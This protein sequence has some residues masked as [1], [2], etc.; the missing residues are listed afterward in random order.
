MGYLRLEGSSDGATE[1]VKDEPG[2]TI[3]ITGA[4]MRLAYRGRGAAAA[5]LDAALRDLAGAGVVR[6]SVDFESFNPEAASFWMKYFTPVVLSV[7]RVPER[8]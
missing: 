1:L 4:Y 3:A 2:R 7:M 5:L 6:C 8:V